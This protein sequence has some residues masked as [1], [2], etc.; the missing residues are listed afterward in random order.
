MKKG[1]VFKIEE[2][3]RLCSRKTVRIHADGQGAKKDVVRPHL[4]SVKSR[5]LKEKS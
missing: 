1:R 2:N 5:A 3:V 4:Y